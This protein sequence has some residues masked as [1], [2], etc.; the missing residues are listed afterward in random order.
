MA[1]PAPAA[2]SIFEEAAP[3]FRVLPKAPDVIRANDHLETQVSALFEKWPETVRK[4]IADLNLTHATIALP[5]DKVEQ[6]LKI[7]K[8]IFTWKQIG[9]WIQPPVLNAPGAGDMPLELPLHVVAPLFMAKHRPAK[10]QKKISISDVSD[11]FAGKRS[12]HLPAPPSVQVVAPVAPLTLVPE[13]AEIKP[14]VTPVQ[15]P[16]SAP[17]ARPSG[18]VPIISQPAKQDLSPNETVKH[19][20]TLP[21]V[22]GAFIAMQD[23]LLVAA[24]LP[25]TFKAETMAAFLPQIFGR[26]HQ[27]TKELKLGG[28]SN[29]TF[30]AE[31][32]PWQI[33][34]TGVVYL[35][36]LG[37]S[38]EDLPGAKLNEIAAELGRQ[39]Q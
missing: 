6:A 10:V 15:V 5:M 34:K 35:V 33:V 14:A 32:V 21:G 12:A 27:Y 37:K 19:L 36:A 18:V 29:L 39:I 9:E 30:V 26:M 11:L 23:G 16:V 17:V 7:G 22:A 28:L 38:G 4:D 2:A 25:E 8:I 24:H 3:A 20:A 31:N 1:R 13:K